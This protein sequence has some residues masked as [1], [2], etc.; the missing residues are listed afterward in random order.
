MIYG[1][2][3]GLARK[4]TSSAVP[5]DLYGIVYEFLPGNSIGRNDAKRN[6]AD[7]HRSSTSLL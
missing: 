6:D 2:R 7:V 5:G 4:M 3:G 1:W